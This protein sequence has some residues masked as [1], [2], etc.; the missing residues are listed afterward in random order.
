[1]RKDAE[2]FK[3]PFSSMQLQTL[4]CTLLCSVL[5]Q[6]ICLSSIKTQ[7]I[8]YMT[9]HDHHPAVL[10]PHPQGEGFLTDIGFEYK[11]YFDH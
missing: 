10:P 8:Q 2:S 3:V 6:F 1:M 5:L 11:T 7:Y 9:V 4:I